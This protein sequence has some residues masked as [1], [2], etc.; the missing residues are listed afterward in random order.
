MKKLILDK[1]IVVIA[2]P[3]EV[4]NVEERPWTRV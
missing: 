3:K 2:K 1:L 4:R